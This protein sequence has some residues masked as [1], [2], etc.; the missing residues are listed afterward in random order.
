MLHPSM[1]DRRTA[2]HLEMYKTHH[3]SP[4]SC[5]ITSPKCYLPSSQNIKTR[6]HT[7]AE[8]KVVTKTNTFSLWK[9]YLSEDSVQLYVKK[10]QETHAFCSL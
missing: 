9:T 1:A 8:D 10:G 6:K 3:A 2:F 5:N 7:E 4:Q